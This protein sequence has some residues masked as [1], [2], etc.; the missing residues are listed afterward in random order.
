MQVGQNGTGESPGG[1]H[2][3]KLKK[4]V[5]ELFTPNLKIFLLA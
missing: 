3:V 5:A 4:L 2:F 1:R